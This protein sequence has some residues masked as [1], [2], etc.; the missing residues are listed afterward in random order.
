MKTTKRILA[1]M[2]FGAILAVGAVPAFAQYGSI[3]FS[4]NTGT[5]YGWGFSWGYGSRQDAKYRAV[6]ECRDKGGANCAEV[7]WFQNTCGALAVGAKGGYG[8]GYG[9]TKDAAE[10][11]ALSECRAHGNTGCR[12]PAARCVSGGPPDATGFMASLPQP[13]KLTRG[14]MRKVQKALAAQGTNPGP[15]DGIYGAKTRAAIQ[16]WQSRK[17]YAAT[18]VLTNVQIQMLIETSQQTT[19]ARSGKEWLSRKTG[20]IYRLLTR[21]LQ[22]AVQG[23]IP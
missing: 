11:K 6:R 22:C 14:Q 4:P 7:G 17:G 9:S 15:A 12:V 1:A 16:D 19:V 2:V 20:E 10:A 5:G 21:L 3:A 18:G 13:A 23:A 8:T